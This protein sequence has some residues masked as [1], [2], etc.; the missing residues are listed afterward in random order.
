MKKF[1]KETVAAIGE[2][3]TAVSAAMDEA[4]AYHDRKSEKWR[5]SDAGT[6]YLAWVQQMELL[7]DAFDALPDAPEH[8]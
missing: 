5:Q 1:D 2:A 4:Q 3:K 8:N 6:C 7:L